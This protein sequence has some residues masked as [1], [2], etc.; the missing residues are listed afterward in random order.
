MKAVGVKVLK[1]NLSRYLRCVREGET[2]YVTDRDTIVAE[3]HRPVRP[4]PPRVSPWDAFLNDE[5]RRGGVRRAQRSGGPRLDNL[6]RDA[7]PRRKV[8]LQHLL[9]EVKD[10]RE[11][12]RG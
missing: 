4:I 1:D 9:D 10:D 7:R 11:M 3:I 12:S 2:V 5:E 6:A 8:D